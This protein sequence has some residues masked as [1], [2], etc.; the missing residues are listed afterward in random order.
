MGHV[1]AKADEC[2]TSD[3]DTGLGASDSAAVQGCV[4]EEMSA[5]TQ[6][7]KPVDYL[8]YYHYDYP[9]FQY[10]Q[11]HSSQVSSHWQSMQVRFSQHQARHVP[12]ST[13]L[14]VQQ[15]PGT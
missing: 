14:A 7:G 1:T 15:W 3:H 6:A 9:Y 8:R 11:H 10:D 13:R 5:E 12:T 4:P 2:N